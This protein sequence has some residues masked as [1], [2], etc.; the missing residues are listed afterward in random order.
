MDGDTKQPLE[1]AGLRIRSVQEPDQ[2]VFD[3]VTD[4]DGII[5]YHP[6]GPGTYSISE[7]IPPQG[8]TA[9]DTSYVFTVDRDG[10]GRV[11]TLITG[12][13]RNR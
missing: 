10:Q 13:K 3:G 8:Y 12:K 2:A 6:P 4:A 5:T 1:G 11:K 7:V 9:A